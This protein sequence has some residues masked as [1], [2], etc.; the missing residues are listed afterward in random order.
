MAPLWI[1]D[2]VGRVLGPVPEGALRELVTTGRLK[3]IS[4]ASR[5]GKAWRP[6]AEFPELSRLL[7]APAPDAR[8]QEE[9]A[10]ATKVRAALAR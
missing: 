10:S 3:S 1:S 9:R 8:H 6:V 5:D 4:S 7:T 2:A